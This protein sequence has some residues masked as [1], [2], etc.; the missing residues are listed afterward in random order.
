MIEQMNLDNFQFD[1]KRKE[2]PEKNIAALVTLDYLNMKIKGFRIYCKTDLITGEVLRWVGP[3]QY[4]NYARK[5]YSS[6]FWMER[7]LWKE[8]E[9][10]ILNDYLSLVRESQI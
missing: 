5:K 3:P 7:E 10:R 4:M 2:P 8:L 9:T 6:L 1:I